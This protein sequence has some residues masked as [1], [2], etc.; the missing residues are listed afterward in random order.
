MSEA[1]FDQYEHYNYEYDKQIFSG[2][3]GKQR[4]KKESEVHTNRNDPSGHSRKILTK[5]MNTENNKKC[6]KN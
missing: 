3:G 1:H 2:H 4:S 5:L 6:T